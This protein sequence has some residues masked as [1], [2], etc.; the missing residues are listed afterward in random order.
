M[1]ERPPNVLWLMTDEQRTDSLGC[2][3]SPW[4]QTP[5]LDRLA[6]EGVLFETAV[7]PSPVCVPARVSLLSGRRPH[8]TGILAN[9]RH[10]SDW[11]P[12]TWVF[13]NHGYQTATF[14][15]Q[16]YLGRHAF[17]TEFH[18]VL[19]DAVHYFQYE[20]GR[21]HEDYDGVRYPSENRGWLFAGRFPEDPAQT[22]EAQCVEAAW[23]WLQA[24]DRERPFLLRMSF[25][26]P[27]TPVVPPAPWDT[28]IDRADIDLPEAFAEPEP[29]APKWVS[30]FLRDCQGSHRLTR[31]Q[32][33]RAHQCY[34]GLAAFLDALFEEL[35]ERMEG[36]GLLEDTVVAFTSDH[37]AHLGD[38]G[39]MQ[40]QTFYE[41]VVSVPLLFHAPRMVA[42]G[43]R[44]RTPVET[45]SL[46]PT[47]L[48]LSGLPAPGYCRELSL[49]ETLTSGEEP[50]GRPVF[51][52][53]SQETWGYRS[54]DML[55]MVRRGP[56]K[57]SL[58][59]G[60]P[61]TDPFS[62]WADAALYNLDEDPLERHNVVR[63]E[64]VRWV[65][66]EL[67]GAMVRRC[68]GVDGE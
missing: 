38:Q 22:A 6:G 14:G 5:C 53:I 27:H 25:N 64:R 24:R 30:E 56:W 51:S 35:L 4:A 42:E 34:Y 63:E 18:K 10:E 65:V 39:M 8:A 49:A 29:G 41:P 33:R 58:F 1:P 50:A 28:L 36:A 61:E 67:V 21:S 55:G 37:G 44:V 19:S 62:E 46:M 43:V 59:W 20:K 60:G 40:K 48:E 17:E 66:E 23:E 47:L 68:G 54:E 3:G 31:E 11:E 15:K 57:L 32:L 16:H 13:R 45:L 52:E 2:Y 9:V 7:T 12:L 26:G